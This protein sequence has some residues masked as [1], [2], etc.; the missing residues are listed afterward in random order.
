[1]VFFVDLIILIITV[2]TYFYTESLI[3]KPASFKVTDLILDQI[4]VQIGDQLQ[5]SVNI[6]NVGDKTGNH[7]IILTIDDEPI[8]TKT[9]QISGKLRLTNLGRSRPEAEVGETIIVSVTATNIG[10]EAGDF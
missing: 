6:T 7:S 9:V 3:P 2:P 8:A 10:D 5:I 1:M 4:W